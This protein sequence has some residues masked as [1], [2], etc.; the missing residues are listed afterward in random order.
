MATDMLIAPLQL[1]PYGAIEI[2]LLL[3]LCP[4]YKD[5]EG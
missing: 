2:Q 1:R 4:R 5:P 3:F